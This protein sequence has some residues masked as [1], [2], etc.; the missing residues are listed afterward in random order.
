MERPE[1]AGVDVGAGR[2]R[3]SRR[4]RFTGG[5]I[6]AR[7]RRRLSA[8]PLK[9]RAQKRETISPPFRVRAAAVP[10][11][12]RHEG[13]ARS[14]RSSIPAVDEPPF[15]R[16][17]AVAG[18]VSDEGGGRHF[19]ILDYSRPPGKSYR[20]SINSGDIFLIPGSRHGIQQR[21]LFIKLRPKFGPY[22]F[23]A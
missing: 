17:R 13:A 10:K 6:E 21:V 20:R 7:D 19:L 14:R 12:R 8:A 15:Q 11:E 2:L 4:Q 18:L 16:R 3:F 1:D 22:F 23:P 5:A 9:N